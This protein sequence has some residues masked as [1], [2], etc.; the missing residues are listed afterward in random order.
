MDMQNLLE[1]ESTKAQ[2]PLHFG[3]TKKAFTLSGWVPASKK[4]RLEKELTTICDGKIDITFKKADQHD[5]PPIKLKNKAPIKSFE[6][7]LTLYELPRYNEFDPTTLMFIT[8]PLFFAFMLGDIG[9]GIVTLIIFS[10]LYKK[11]EVGKALLKVMIFASIVTIIFG[12]GFGEFFGFE[13]ISVESG[14]A[15]CSNTGLCLPIHEIGEGSD[16]KIV[17]D[18]PRIL[19]R[20]HARFMIGGQSILAVLVIGVIIGFFHLNFGLVLGFINELPHG[21]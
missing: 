21:L 5:T 6:S 1:Q 10:L 2:I 14:Q 15:L 16:A 8:F 11:L 7:L 13:H 18:F 4:N 12:F 20:G 9:Y 19:N 17:A 3:G